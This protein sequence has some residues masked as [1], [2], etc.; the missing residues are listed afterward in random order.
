MKKNE[1]CPHCGVVLRMGKGGNTRGCMVCTQLICI[2][3]S[4]HGICETHFNQANIDQEK[5][6]IKNYK[7]YWL[8]QA[9]GII[10]P[11]IIIYY[12][13]FSDHLTD[14]NAWWFLLLQALMFLLILI[15]VVIIRKFF[16]KRMKKI[17]A[18]STNTVKIL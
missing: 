11:M 18:A 8:I 4:K 15:N 6:Y 9:I 12:L 13:G 5:S 1:N 2:R 10:I 14:D 3:C 17:F 7:L 16:V